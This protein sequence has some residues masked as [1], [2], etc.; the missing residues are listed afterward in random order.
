[1]ENHS[2]ETTVSLKPEYAGF[3]LRFFAFVIDSMIISIP[4]LLAGL[5]IPVAGGIMISFMYKPFFESSALRATPGKA[6][7]GLQVISLEGK[8]ISFKSSFIRHGAEFIS[9]LFLFF[10][11]LLNL[12]TERRQTLHDILAETVVVKSR[13]PEINYLEAWTEEVTRVFSGK[14]SSETE[15]VKAPPSHV[16]EE[17]HDL[18][19]KGILTEAE[20]NT[21]KGEILAK[22]SP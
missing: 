19:Q 9:M 10:G 18:Y 20:Y 11:Y 1:M 22:W 13:P 3:W 14:K 16:L 12:F 8:R 5:L 4:S 2:Q 15:V 6:L 17:L 21:K 7:L